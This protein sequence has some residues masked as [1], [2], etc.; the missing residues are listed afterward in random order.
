[1][2][3][4]ITLWCMIVVTQGLDTGIDLYEFF[5]GCLLRVAKLEDRAV[6]VMA[7]PCFTTKPTVEGVMSLS[8]FTRG[9]I[10][11]NTYFHEEYGDAMQYDMILATDDLVSSR[12]SH[13]R[14]RTI[15]LTGTWRVG[16]SRMQGLFVPFALVGSGDPVRVLC[17]LHNEYT[18][19]SW[20][21]Y[22]WDICTTCRYRTY[23]ILY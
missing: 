4:K 6:H 16:G 7:P 15:L 20:S 11:P 21:I 19:C 22:C 5:V 1:M 18:G 12:E 14:T 10:S 13:D 3:T 8:D 17:L 23:V 9:K 2:K